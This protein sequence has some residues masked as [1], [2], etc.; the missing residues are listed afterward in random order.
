MESR[1]RWEWVID[2]TLRPFYP[3]NETRYPFYRRLGKPSA[4]LNGCGISPSQ[5]FDPRTFQAVVKRCTECYPGP[6]N[7]G[8]Q[9]LTLLQ[10]AQ[11]KLWASVLCLWAWTLHTFYLARIQEFLKKDPSNGPRFLQ[12][13]SSAGGPR[14]FSSIIQVYAFQVCCCRPYLLSL[15]HRKSKIFFFPQGADHCQKSLIF[16]IQRP[17]TAST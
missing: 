14:I 1:G 4:G 15:C 17:G 13:L 16:G 7:I 3:R 5:G 6:D 8:A 11:T 2:S 9:Y 10:N 12:L